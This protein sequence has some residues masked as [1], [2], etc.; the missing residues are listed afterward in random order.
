MR[1]KELF[2]FSVHKAF[3]LDGIQLHFDPDAVQEIARIAFN[4]KQV[5]AG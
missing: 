1:A 2:D 5:H 4:K 3:E